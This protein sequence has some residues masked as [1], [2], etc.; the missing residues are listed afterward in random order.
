M[1]ALANLYAISDWS[2]QQLAIGVATFQLLVALNWYVSHPVHRARLSVAARGRGVRT[3]RR[4]TLAR[5]WVSRG[6]AIF[7]SGSF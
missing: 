2:I 5:R 6:S 3:A 7:S 4:R 1:G